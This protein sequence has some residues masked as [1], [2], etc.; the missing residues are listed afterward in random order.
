MHNNL[1]SLKEIHATIL[2]RHVR[3]AKPAN[4]FH[5]YN[6]IGYGYFVLISWMWNFVNGDIFMKINCSIMIQMH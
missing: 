6:S 4:L 3:L 2:R 1:T 5:S